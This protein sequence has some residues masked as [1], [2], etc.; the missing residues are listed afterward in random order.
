MPSSRPASPSSLA[1]FAGAALFVLGTDLA[2]AETA[3]DARLRQLA[4]QAASYA[5]EVRSLLAKGADPNVPD[6][7][8]RTAL[9]GAARLG[10]VETMS[11]LLDAGGNP[12][13][14]DEDGNTPL[15]FASDAS[16]APLMVHHS[17]ATIQ[18]LLSARANPNQ[19]NAA[20]RTPL[21]LAAGSHDEPG[22]VAALLSSGASPNR[23]DGEGDTALHAAVGPNLG[24]PTVVAALL[25]GGAD[26][27]ITNADGL[28]ALQLFVWDGPDQG[29]TAAMLVEA[30]AD[31][32]R[33]FGNGDAPL[34]AAIRRGGSRGKVEVAEALLATGANPC[35]RDGRGFIPYSVAAEGGAIHRALDRAGGHDLGC[36]AQ[37]ETVA[38][39]SGERRRIQEALARAGF[40]PGPA[41]G[42]FGPR[43]RRAIQGWQQANGYAATGDLTRAQA[44]VLL[45]ESAVADTLTPTCT[46]AATG[47]ECWKEIADRPGCHVWDTYFETGLSVTWSGPCSGGIAEGRGELVW[48]TGESLVQQAGT[49]S[50]GRKQGDW[51][52]SYHGGEE[53]VACVVPSLEYGYRTEREFAYSGYFENGIAQGH[54]KIRGCFVVHG[55]IGRRYFLFTDEGPVVDGEKHGHWIKRRSDGTYSEEGTYVTGKKHGTWTEESFGTEYDTISLVPYVDGEKHGRETIRGKNTGN[56][57]VKVYSRGEQVGDIESC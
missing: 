24:W 37:G 49:L 48:T 56:C 18:V 25:D 23:K 16:Q 45:T 36:D 51:V 17:I 14:R 9:H 42:K 31:P 39:D 50:N 8:G 32:D 1:L 2:H 41:D 47:A 29:R 20:G 7:A 12:N 30:G 34:H 11:A 3:D 22:G 13:K 6:H 26:P 10:A 4:V 44:E 55:K 46:G 53:N 28:T 33:K 5:G 19:T 35:I 52:L 43:T 27:R 40:D 57:W 38:L 54:W 21:H 15:H